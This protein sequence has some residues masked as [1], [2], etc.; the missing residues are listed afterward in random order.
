M[1]PPTVDGIFASDI[2]QVLVFKLLHYFCSNFLKMRYYKLLIL[3]CFIFSIT[4]MSCKPDNS[5]TI[6]GQIKGAQDLSVYLD[7]KSL[8]KSISSLGNTPI[9]TSGNFSITLPE[10]IA[11]GLYRLRIGTKGIDLICDGTEKN[12]VLAGQL[13]ELANFDYTVTGSP[14][15]EIYHQKI[16]GLRDGKLRRP[17]FDEFVNTT[18]P[19][20][21][22]ALHFATTPLD[23]AENKL[24][25]NMV[26]KVKTTYPE[27]AVLPQ[28]T[29]LSNDMKRQHIL[30]MSKYPVKKGQPAPDIALPGVDGK[31]RKLSDLKGKVVLLD[32]WASWCSPCRRANPHV[33]SLYEKYNK[34]GFEVFNVSLDGLSSKKRTNLSQATIKSKLKASKKKWIDAIA[35]DKLSWN[36][37]V[38]DLMEWE[39]VGAQLYG[40]SSIPTTFLIGRDGR[41][42]EI[43]P[44]RNLEKAIQKHL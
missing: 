16:N 39:S 6:S 11:A 15:S 26:D 28:L 22:I 35:T 34:D 33:V 42:V 5:T 29:K 31:I 3:S 13:A 27:A 9:D 30:A 37:H 20:L 1:I 14:L 4:A 23:P 36:N 17:E 19:L 25:E 32:F 12:I 40:V 8:N 24:F 41:I 7:I 44:K 43:N 18:D 21:A 38:S 2:Q 10:G